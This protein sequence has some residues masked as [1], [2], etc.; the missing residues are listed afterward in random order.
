[1]TD[2][3]NQTLDITK[4]TVFDDV[5]FDFVVF[6]IQAETRGVLIGL[7]AMEDDTVALFGQ[8]RNRGILDLETTAFQDASRF[9]N[10]ETVNQNGNVS[11]IGAG[12]VDD[13]VVVV[14]NLGTWTLEGA[15]QITTQTAGPI[16]SRFV[17]LGTL[18]D[19]TNG[20][21]VMQAPLISR[22]TVDVEGAF[23]F[24]GAVRLLAGGVEGAG[25]ATFGT[26]LFDRDV[27]SVESVSGYAVRMLGDVT[28]SS[29]DIVFNSLTL[30]GGATFEVKGFDTS[31]ILKTIGG[32]GEVNVEGLATI[33]NIA[34]TGDVTFVNSSEVYSGMAP[35]TSFHPDPDAAFISAA[36]NALGAIEIHNMAGASWTA[37]DSTTFYAVNGAANASFVNDGS[38]ENAS[39]Y[40][41]TFSM[42]VVNN[43]SIAGNPFATSAPYGGFVFDDAISGD[44]TIEIGDDA[45][46]V[47]GAVAAG[48]SFLFEGA[49][50]DAGSP[51]LT[52]NDVQDFAGTVSGLGGFSTYDHIAV[53]TSEFALQSFQADTGD[54]G[55]S[56]V[57]SNGTSSAYIH[58]LGSFDPTRFFV[59]KDGDT[60]TIEYIAA[61]KA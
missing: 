20:D 11:L 58:L 56:L 52:I 12:G 5:V 39:A 45:V 16:V 13:D 24:E 26:V 53:N 47:N 36:P 51:T 34:L 23:T 33:F 4:Y 22:G 29:T 32:V 54:A 30:A 50:T 10:A 28:T 25:A 46:T 49:N 44:G 31:L 57:F 1:M 27:I 43:G 37:H 15:T 3:S 41:T 2:I 21:N 17:N 9:V 38:F 48:Q 40:A 42:A 7:S 35:Q 8:L 18:A 60:T 59:A 6:D 55:G 14:R 19:A 61:V